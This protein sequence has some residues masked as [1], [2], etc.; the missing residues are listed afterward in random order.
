MLVT[1]LILAPRS[2]SQQS[3]VIYEFEDTL[4]YITRS[5]ATTTIIVIID[6][7]PL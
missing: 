1:S 6:L 7:K 4:V 3:F 5:K 2:R